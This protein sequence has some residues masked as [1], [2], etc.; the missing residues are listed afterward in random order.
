MARSSLWP[1]ERNT[2]PGTAA[3]T[4]RRRQRDGRRRH[5][6][7]AGLAGACLARQH[8]VRLEEHPLERDPLLVERVEHGVERGLGRL[9]A[10][11]DGVVPVHQNLGLD[12]RDHPRLLTQGRVARERVGI[13]LDRPIRRK[14]G[15]DR[16]HGAPLGEAGPQ[17][18]VLGE[19]LAQPVE[20]FR[21]LLPG[22]GRE[23][24]RAPVDLDA[25][26]DPLAR[27]DLDQRRPVVRLLA[28]R[29]VEEDDAAHVV[30]H[31]RGGEEHL[32]V[33]AAG[34]LS[35]RDA[36]RLEAAPDAGVTLVGGEDALARRD[37][38]ASRGLQP[39][40]VHSFSPLTASGI[41]RA[42][43]AVPTDS[44][45][46][47]PAST[48]RAIARRQPRAP[49]TGISGT[50]ASRDGRLGSREQRR[51][52]DLDEPF[53]VGLARDYH[54]GRR[55]KRLAEVPPPT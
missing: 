29:L 41:D 5:L 19:P 6:R 15:A 51:P 9:E 47:T 28:D 14:A 31:A 33:A 25:R 2:T 11:L 32:A 27:E 39:F 37:E 35:V 1:P 53:G 26:N 38:G 52:F 4:V 22:R 34:L 49:R 13:G 30:R 55:R 17:R 3:G 24:L 44:H 45:R 54:R 8:H 40:H 21:H 18:G 42:V 43:R 36:Q 48:G 7:D 10:A 16:D 23:R 20:A 46:K 12:D 50:S